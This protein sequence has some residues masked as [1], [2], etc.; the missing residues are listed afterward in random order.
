MKAMAR[1]ATAEVVPHGVL[2]IVWKDGAEGVVDLGPN[3]AR[4]RVFTY[5][6]DPKNFARLQVEEYGHSIGWVDDSGVQ[7]DFGA[8]NLK[9]M[10]EDQ[11]S[12]Y[13]LVTNMRWS[14]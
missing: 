12:L 9:K 4:G 8:D 11:A 3:M 1:I 10:A 14:A 2:E 13:A 6:L 5:L 7:I